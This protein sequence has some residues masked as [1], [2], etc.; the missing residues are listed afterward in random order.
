M[1]NN[2]IIIG[3]RESRLAL[4]QTGMVADFLREKY[5]ERS[6]ELLKMTTTGDRILDRRLDQIGG[7]GLFVKELDRALAAGECDLCVHSMKDL[8]MELP[9]ELPLLGC[10][11]REDP[12]DVLVLP[13]GRKEPDPSL[14]IGTSSRRRILQV[15]KLY[16]DLRFESVR[17]NLQTRLKKLDEG[18]YGGLILAAAGLK[19]MGLEN[20]ISRYFSAE[21]V[22]PAAGQGVLAIQ[23]RA[24]T[25]DFD[26]DGFIDPGTM[27]ATLAERAFVRRLNGGCSSPVTAYGE[28]DGESL[29]LRGLYYDEEKRVSRTEER[30]AIVRTKEEAEALGRGLAEQLIPGREI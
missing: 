16:P 21:E 10:S 27:L 1:E 12:R 30:S 24:D 8:P 26:L 20:R 3:T 17:G 19:R 22:I 9:E 2:R 29:A 15:Q 18:L 7:K 11:R 13:A 14:P 6:V 4:V 28:F 25:Y 23:G 5:P